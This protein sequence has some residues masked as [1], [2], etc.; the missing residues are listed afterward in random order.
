LEAGV[1]LSEV[2]EYGHTPFFVAAWRGRAKAVELLLSWGCDPS[3]R[4][5]NGVSP[6]EAAAAC[7]HEAVL[8]ALA[9]YGIRSK[10]SS[11]REKTRCSGIDD[12]GVRVK[13]V[14]VSSCCSA[15]A[16]YI[17][18]AFTEDFLLRLEK[19]WKSLP[20]E[21][22][23]FDNSG[24]S[25][26][27]EGP[28]LN[29]QARKRML[30]L[31]SRRGD[32]SQ[33]ETAPRRSY[34]CDVEGW[35]LRELSSALKVASALGES[36]SQGSRCNEVSNVET[37]VPCETAYSHMR[38]LHYR[39]PGGYL[40]P[41]VDLARTDSLTGRKSTHTFI[42]YLCG[43][44]DGREG[45]ETVLLE[46]ANCDSPALATVAPVRG[47]LFLFPHD[48]PH[49]AQPVEEPPKLILRGEMR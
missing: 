17:D 25:L 32:R 23:A 16:C 33:Q 26:D 14:P 30:G 41:H 6:F 5:N 3:R 38:F 22:K 12:Q 13:N 40:A 35:I 43:A 31:G 2:D 27:D 39:E 11:L 45:G 8:L 46:K 19:L 44:R 10:I 15:G 49:K 42:L 9:N 28:R 4:S 37:S 1:D 36:D 24:P 34:L 7:G 29:A 20:V 47:R 18:G 48:C 21:E